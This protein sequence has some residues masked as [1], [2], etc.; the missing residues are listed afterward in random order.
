MNILGPALLDLQMIFD[1]ELHTMGTIFFVNGIGY[2]VGGILGGLV[3]NRLNYHL[4]FALAGMLSSAS[5]A[6]APWIQHVA[7]FIPFTGGILGL[8]CGLIEAGR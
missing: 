7:V 3:A 1:V 2:A 6:V 4:V 5:L 8:T